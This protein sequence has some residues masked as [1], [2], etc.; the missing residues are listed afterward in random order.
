MEMKKSII[1]LTIALF[2]NISVV[3]AQ[4]RILQQQLLCFKSNQLYSVIA[5]TEDN[6][7]GD[8]Q[9][10]GGVTITLKEGD[11]EISHFVTFE[12]GENCPADGFM[13]IKRKTTSSR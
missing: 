12:L 8:N 6:R 2:I 9:Q 13:G 5:S 4:G 3:S 1:S 11:K 10:Y 7:N